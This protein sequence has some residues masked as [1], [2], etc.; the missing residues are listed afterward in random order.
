MKSV[1]PWVT[2]YSWLILAMFALFLSGGDRPLEIAVW[3]APMLLL[4]FFREV[5]L[6]K[7]IVFTLPLVTATTLLADWGM[8]PIPMPFL[9]ILTVINSAIALIPYIADRLLSRSLPKSRRAA[10]KRRPPFPSP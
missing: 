6:W 7:G 10:G 1:K 4:R 8:T 9:A 2:K 3:L 5:K